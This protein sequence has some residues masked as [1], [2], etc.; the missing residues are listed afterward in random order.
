MTPL[1]IEFKFS[2]LQVKNI[3]SIIGKS[4]ELKMEKEFRMI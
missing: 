2:F 4:I 3:Y 1:V